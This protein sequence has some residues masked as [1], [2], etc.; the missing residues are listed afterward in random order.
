MDNDDIEVRPHLVSF[1]QELDQQLKETSVDDVV[2]TVSPLHSVAMLTSPAHNCV[3]LDNQVAMEM[4]EPLS[5]SHNKYKEQNE[6]AFVTHGNDTDEC[7]VITNKQCVPD[8]KPPSSTSQPVNSEPNEPRYKPPAGHRDILFPMRDQKSLLEIKKVSEGVIIIKWRHVKLY[9]FMSECFYNNTFYLL[10][11]TL[12]RRAD[13][14][15]QEA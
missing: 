8:Y 6:T 2:D 15:N 13:S 7:N 14:D 1:Q 11:K 9:R 5:N 10:L 12:E 3:V 4:Q